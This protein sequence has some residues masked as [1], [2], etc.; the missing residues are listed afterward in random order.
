MSRL[1]DALARAKMTKF[2]RFT[3]RITVPVEEI[4]NEEIECAID[5]I[6]GIGEFEIIEAIFTNQPGG[7]DVTT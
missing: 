5:E 1:A 7:N 6:N 2:C 3:V 4:N